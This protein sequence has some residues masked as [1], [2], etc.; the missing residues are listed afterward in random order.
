MLYVCRNINS[1]A[2]IAGRNIKFTCS[3]ADTKSDTS[4]AKNQME[5][6]YSKGIRMFGE[7]THIMGQS[8][9]DAGSTDMGKII[10]IIPLVCNKYDFMGM[11]WWLSAKGDMKLP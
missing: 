6:M 5:I 4:E 11:R 2:A 10:A 1:Y 7:T 3:I 9:L 8:C